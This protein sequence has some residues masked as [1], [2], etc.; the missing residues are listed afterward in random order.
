MWQGPL[1]RANGYQALKSRIASPRPWRA[2]LS[3]DFTRA[4]SIVRS[5]NLL[6][7]CSTSLPATISSIFWV[8][9]PSQPIILFF[10]PKRVE[11]IWLQTLSP[12]EQSHLTVR[13][14]LDLFNST[15]KAFLTSP[16]MLTI[17]L[18]STIYLFPN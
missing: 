9:L 3:S 4:A 6:N 5:R 10:S 11:M 16:L 1:N 13:L 14:L 17:K 8:S 18:F 15:E 7:A 12:D 2:S